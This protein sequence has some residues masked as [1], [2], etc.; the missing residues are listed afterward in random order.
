MLCNHTADCASEIVWCGPRRRLAIKPP[1]A[2]ALAQASPLN[3]NIIFSNVN[4]QSTSP[5]NP[6]PLKLRSA[7][8]PSSRF[9]SSLILGRPVHSLL[10]QNEVSR[11]PSFR[12]RR[13]IFRLVQ[14][15]VAPSLPHHIS[16]RP[17]SRLLT[18]N[19]LKWAFRKN[20]GPQ[21][22]EKSRSRQHTHTAAIDI[23]QFFLNTTKAGSLLQYPDSV[24]Q[25][26]I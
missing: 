20:L 21:S 9:S 3:I 5:S 6:R 15:K 2:A 23:P 18:E 22:I 14:A 12:L 19:W 13:R 8:D 1:E 25:Y 7:P 4:H 24:T 10:D 26:K 11:S 16:S 17:P